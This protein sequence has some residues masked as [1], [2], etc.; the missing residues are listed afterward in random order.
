MRLGVHHGT[1]AAGK[2]TLSLP[3]SG[4]QGIRQRRAATAWGLAGL[5]LISAAG[6]MLA[7]VIDAHSQPSS[8]A[9]AFNFN[10]DPG[11]PLEGRPAPNFT[12][13]NQFGQ[14]VSLSQFRGKVVI[15]AFVDSECTSICPLTTTSMLEAVR[16][17]GSQAQHV[18]LIGINA[19]PIATSVADV[20]AYSAAHGMTDRWEFLTGTKVQLSTVWHDYNV[21]VAAIHGNI[22]HEPAVYVIG[23]NGGERTLFLTQMAY[24][25]VTQQA[26][27]LAD[28]AAALL[29]G[30]PR[31]A[32]LVSLG[33]IAG[34]RPSTELSLAAVGG[35]IGPRPVR[36]GPGHPHLYVF[37]ATWLE[38]TSNVAAQ[39]EGLNGYV[40]M[41]HQNGWPSLVLVDEAVTE[42]STDALAGLLR[43]LGSH[44]DYPVVVDTSGRLADGYGV[45]NLP[46]TVLTSAS[47]EILL[48]NQNYAGWPSTAGLEAAVG[49]AEAAAR[50]SK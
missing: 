1:Q 49:R 2:K 38:E 43:D 12:L 32:K 23:P 39:L 21:Y 47:G 14:P 10:I 30:H 5:V 35:K 46:C 44:L 22:D 26:Q 7:R 13:S 42:P 33:A 25:S 40:T 34:T 41:A 6:V 4:G 28:S 48:T 8:V 37:F 20:R 36:I 18:Q 45:E 3:S 27:L 50:R 29:P 17:L 15:L 11:T 9:G 19:N 16:M 31:V 24:A